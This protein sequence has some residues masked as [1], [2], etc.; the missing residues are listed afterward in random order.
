MVSMGRR[1]KLPIRRLELFNP[2]RPDLEDRRSKITVF[3]CNR[4]QNCF[5][6]RICKIT[7]FWWNKSRNWTWW[8]PI[9]AWIWFISGG[10]IDGQRCFNQ[11]PP[12]TIDGT[13]GDQRWTTINCY[14]GWQKIY[15]CY[16]VH[17]LNDL[18]RVSVIAYCL[19]HLRVVY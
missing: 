12:V 17:P 5:S 8:M 7:V 2:L 15:Y 9:W 3:C 11:C 10:A 14:T 4:A 19:V 6:D 1:N 18:Y 16:T 13:F